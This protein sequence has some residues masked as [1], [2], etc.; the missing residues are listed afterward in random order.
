MVISSPSRSRVTASSCST[1]WLRSIVIVSAIAPPFG[2]PP[3][4]PSLTPC[5]HAGIP[6]AS[7]APVLRPGDGVGGLEPDPDYKEGRMSLEPA[8]AE[9]RRATMI[10]IALGL[11]LLIGGVIGLVYIVVATITSAIL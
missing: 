10:S 4:P 11:L 1:H 7:D 5:I 9:L 8:A 3:V 6:D 2:C